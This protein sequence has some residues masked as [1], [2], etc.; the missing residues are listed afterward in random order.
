[1]LAAIATPRGSAGGGSGWGM[2]NGQDDTAQEYLKARKKAVDR[3]ES[4]SQGIVSANY[5]VMIKEMKNKIVHCNTIKQIDQSLSNVSITDISVLGDED[6]KLC[7][8]VLSDLGARAKYWMEHIGT[9][10][11][12]ELC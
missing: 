4:L 11:M 10:L 12:I 3:A 2:L 5:D 1:V 9:S 6:A 7:K 8:E